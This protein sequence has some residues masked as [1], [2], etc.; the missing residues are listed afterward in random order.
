MWAWWRLQECSQIWRIY[1]LPIYW[2]SDRKQ[3]FMCGQKPYKY[4][5]GAFR[6]LQ[7]RYSPKGHTK[8]TGACVRLQIIEFWGPISRL[9]FGQIWSHLLQPLR[10]IDFFI[11]VTVFEATP[12]AFDGLEG[13]QKLMGGPICYQN[14]IWTAFRLH[15]IN[16]FLS[17]I[18]G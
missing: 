11:G 9:E 2:V 16:N 10:N 18:S 3:F 14:E 1:K 6:P 12:L 5:R 8:F 15:K 17:E 13:R 7:Q 4:F